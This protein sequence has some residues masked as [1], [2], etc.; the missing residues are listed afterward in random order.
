MRIM[1][2]ELQKSVLC[3]KIQDFGKDL[4]ISL[5]IVYDFIIDICVCNTRMVC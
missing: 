1:D 5:L 2:T 4:M 3:E